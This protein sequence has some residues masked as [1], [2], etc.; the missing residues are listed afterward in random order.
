MHDALS[1]HDEIN[2]LQIS[3]LYLQVIINRNQTK[4][5]IQMKIITMWRAV[6]K[7]N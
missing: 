6:A 5:T 1:Y 7:Q 2:Q 4:L 3:I